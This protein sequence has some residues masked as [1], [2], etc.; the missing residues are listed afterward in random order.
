MVRKMS[1]S[2]E[3]RVWA[4]LRETDPT[5]KST[6]DATYA[7]VFRFNGNVVAYRDTPEGTVEVRVLNRGAVQ[8]YFELP[9]VPD[10]PL[11][12]YLQDN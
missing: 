6:Y 9:S 8:E 1:K 10:E 2:E 3:K 7:G 11:H 12:R 4:R 5:L